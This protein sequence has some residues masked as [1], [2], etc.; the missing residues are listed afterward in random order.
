MIEIFVICLIALV[1]SVWKFGRK[2]VKR[3]INGTTSDVKRAL[4]IA[5]IDSIKKQLKKSKESLADLGASTE[6]LKLDKEKEEARSTNSMLAANKA[7]DAGNKPDAEEC[8]NLH[9]NAK[10]NIEVISADIEANDALYNKVVAEIASKQIQV[11]KFESS[12][13]RSDTRKASNTLR[14]NIARDS[15]LQEGV[16]SLEIDETCEEELEAIAYEK[17]AKDLGNDDNILDK[18]NQQDSSKEF[19]E[20]FKKED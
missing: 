6:R 3:A 17:L 16:F 9:L 19:E 14:R 18:Y 15:A 5:P 7:K 2:R 13:A 12:Q 20:F 8:F 10:K 1:I 11:T 4:S